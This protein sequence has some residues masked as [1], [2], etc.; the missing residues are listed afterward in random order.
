MGRTIKLDGGYIIL[1]KKGLC[2]NL[3][4]FTF[5][6]LAISKSSSVLLSL[7]IKRKGVQYPLYVVISDIFKELS[8]IR[9]LPCYDY[10]WCGKAAVV[11]VHKKID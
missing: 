5:C 3:L 11:S 10:V 4:T 2:K 8:L 9:R 1:F 7:K 6:A